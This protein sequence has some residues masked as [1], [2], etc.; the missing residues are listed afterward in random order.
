MARPRGFDEQ[1]VLLL[2]ADAFVAG[3][4]EGTS[5]DDLVKELGLHRGS[6][7]KA[8]GSKHGLFLAALRVRVDGLRRDLSEE[9]PTTDELDL[10]LVAALERGRDD[11][12]AAA[13]VH[14]ALS[15]LDSAA[16]PPGAAT[17]P[18][19]TRPRHALGLLDARLFD[20]LLPPEPSDDPDRRS[21]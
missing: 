18:T 8:F 11:P 15:L 10:L 20:R 7:Y 17:T 1:E 14:Q 13:L 4:F 6:L 12:S 16:P 9:P 19:T 5:I 2:A 3:G 21:T